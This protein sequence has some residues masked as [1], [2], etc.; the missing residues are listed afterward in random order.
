MTSLNPQY[1]HKGP[2]SK[3]SQAVGV[4][5]LHMTWGETVQSTAVRCWWFWENHAPALLFHCSPSE[6]IFVLG[7]VILIT[8]W[9]S[10]LQRKF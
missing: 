7:K 8:Y 3:H 1:L 4:G 6:G 10:Q 9:S 5:L 2:V